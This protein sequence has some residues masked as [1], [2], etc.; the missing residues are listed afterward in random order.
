MS[1]IDI[2]FFSVVV[3]TLTMVGL[4]I[5]VFFHNRRSLTNIVFFGL[6]FILSAWGLLNFV[7]INN[8][9]STLFWINMVLLIA[10]LQGPIFFFFIFNFPSSTNKLGSFWTIAV[11]ILTILNAIIS[12]FVFSGFKMVD[13][14]ILPLPN[15]LIIIFGLLSIGFVIAGVEQ[16]F[17]KFF[18]SKGIERKRIGYIMS[19][20]VVMFFLIIVFNFIVVNFFNNV[21]FILYSSLFILPF[22]V[23][24]GYAILKHGLLDGKAIA[25]ELLVM[26]LVIVLFIE[27]ILSGSVS[28][29]VYKV[30]FAAFVGF[31]GVLLV[32][33]V[34]RE[35]HQ[36]QELARLTQS[37]KKANTRLKEL[38]QLKTEFLS[39]ATHQLRTPLSIIKGYTSLLDEG[40]YG[41]VNKQQK[42]IFNNID[43]SNERLIKLVDEFLNVS[44]IEQGRTQYSFKEMILPEMV[45]GVISELKEK[46]NLKNIELDLKIEK[47]INKIVADED[48][49]R[50]SLYNF[51]DNAIK[52]SPAK[53]TIKIFIEKKKFGIQARIV[54]S[55]VGL[56]GKDLKNLFQKFYR[57]LHV[58]NEV[59]GTGL[60]LFV[61]K[62]FIEAH[63]GKV[64]AKSNGIGKGS[65]FGFWI[66]AK[67]KSKSKKSISKERPS[68]VK[69]K[70]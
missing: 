62:Q 9:T 34:Y 21:N 45:M 48:R 10:A 38:D 11:F 27:G 40:A 46:A 1:G 47:G 23:L 56:D 24:T 60:G 52:Y 30:I 25:T 49:L 5:I 36:R 68:T 6:A 59:Q 8:H 35:V 41:V 43:I 58:S 19:G 32:R 53:S 20:F 28:S 7:A 3:A 69:A 31:L 57:S 22:V 33:S 55:G 61:V 15:W 18:Q 50:H 12:Q 67:A 26:I 14:K 64:W 29:I 13:G 51:V 44:R 37:L 54:D 70:S 42:E 4:G 39:I 66:P 65:E 63:K 2:H 16:L 17:K